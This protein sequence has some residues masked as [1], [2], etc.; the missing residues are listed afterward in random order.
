[1]TDRGDPLNSQ[2]PLDVRVQSRK[3]KVPPPRGS[4]STTAA[5]RMSCASSMIR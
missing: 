4:P 3:Y 1:M 5:A 2:L